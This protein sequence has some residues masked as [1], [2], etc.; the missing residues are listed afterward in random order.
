MNYP[1][2]FDTSAF[3]A[4]KRI[5]V[6]RTMAIWSM[7]L[8]FLIL[9]TCFVLPWLQ[10]NKS[11]NP[12][13]IYVNGPHGE[14]GLVDNSAPKSAISYSYSMQQALVGVFTKKWFTISVGRER[15]ERNWGSHDRAEFCAERVPTTSWDPEGGGIYCI[16]DDKLYQNFVTNVLP[17]Y[18][19]RSMVGERWSININKTDIQPFGPIHEDGGTWIVHGRIR[20]NINGEFNIVAYVKVGRDMEKYPQSLGYY[21]ASYNA[22]RGE[23]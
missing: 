6:S 9:G 22:F 1:D 18:Q 21:I 8:L 3:P 10:K 20:S 17:G 12:F 13:V 11:I 7:A 14:W 15:N 19:E 5:A 16:A 2:D 4:G 23:Q